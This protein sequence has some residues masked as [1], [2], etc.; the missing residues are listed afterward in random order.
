MQNGP[1]H[2][3]QWAILPQNHIWDAIVE[4]EKF[5]SPKTDLNLNSNQVLEIN[6]KRKKRKGKEKGAQSFWPGL[7]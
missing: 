7:G 5:K 2:E 4:T 1:H 3:L 6:E